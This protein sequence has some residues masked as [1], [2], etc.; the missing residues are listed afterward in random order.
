MSNAY[1]E[2]VPKLLAATE[3]GRVQDWV[4]RL[5]EVAREAGLRIDSISWQGSP[6]AVA[7]N[8]VDFAVRRQREEKLRAVIASEQS[9]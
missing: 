9:V 3:K 6:N 5:A 1:T 8:V 4:E 7:H 2:L